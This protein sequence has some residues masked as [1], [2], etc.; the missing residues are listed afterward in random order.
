MRV[1]MFDSFHEETFG[2]AP[3]E[4]EMAA[5][6]G[7]GGDEGGGAE[8]VAAPGWLC[9]LT[10]LSRHEHTWNTHGRLC[11]DTRESRQ[12]PCVV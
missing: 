7:G 4:V 3:Q 11:R 6:G 5:A 1:K 8:G 2:W 10:R 12:H 9:E